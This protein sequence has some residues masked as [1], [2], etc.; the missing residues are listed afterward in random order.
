MISSTAR[1]PPEHRKE[2]MGACLRVSMFPDIMEHLPA[3]ADE[4]IA[5]SLDMVDRSEIIWVWLL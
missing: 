2:A 1:D 4:A 5:A 3:S